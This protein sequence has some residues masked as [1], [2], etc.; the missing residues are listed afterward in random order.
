MTLAAVVMAAGG[1]RR[2]DGDGHKLLADFRGRPLASWAIG[3]AGAAGLDELVVVTG[4]VDLDDLI[5]EGVTRL[6]NPG[7]AE[8]QATSMQVALAHA[9]RVGHGAV[10]LGLADTPLVPASAWRAVAAQPGDLVTA[11]FDG[12]RRPPV[13]VAGA[14]WSDL[15]LDGDE[16]ARVLLAGGA[17]P[18]VE[19]A[20]EGQP[21]DIDTM[22]DLR[23]WS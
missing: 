13:K 21:V 1:G 22:E 15:P 16:G 17:S 2:W 19:V 9:R 23:Q 3:A 7:W 12:R 14:L 20:C 4:P 10:V 5:P 11:T 8:G 6:H 18:V